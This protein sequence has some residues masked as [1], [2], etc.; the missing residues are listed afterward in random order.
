LKAQ[1]AKARANIVL[2]DADLI[3]DAQDR[4]RQIEGELTAVEKELR[5]TKPP[6]EKDINAETLEI[7][8]ALAFMSLHFRA[9]SEGF[10]NWRP[11]C[12]KAIKKIAGIT[13]HTIINGSGKGTR[14]QFESGEIA[15]R[16]LGIV[17]QRENP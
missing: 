5:E 3:P 2:L 11:Q 7:L 17:G 10:D 9:V 16:T 12:R 8:D 4:I 1:A 13:I 6:A 14:H 15:F